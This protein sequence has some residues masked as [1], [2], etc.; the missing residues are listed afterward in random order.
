MDGHT[1]DLALDGPA[2]T[3]RLVDLP[4]VSGQ[5]K[6]LADA[7]EGALRPLAHLKVDR[8]GNNVVART[9][10][11]RAERVVLAGH[12]DTV[13]IADNVPSRLDDDGVL[14]GC[15]TSDMKAG[16][17][18]QLRIAA[19]VPEPNRDLTFV[20]YDNEEVAA[21]LN[22]LGKVAEAHPEWLE[23]DFA[24]LL[25][26]SDGEV[27]GGCQGTLRMHLRLDGERSHSA[28]SWMGSNAVH[29][30]APVL[31]KLASYEPRRP[32]IDGLEYREGLNAVGIEG[33][34]AT[35][36]IPDA[37]T[38]VVNYRYAPD[39]TPEQAEAHVHEVFADC[40]VAA[41]TVDDHSGAAM[42]GL[43]HP[44]AVA[45]MAAVGGTARPKFG[46]TDVSRFGSLGVPAVNYGPGDPLFAHKRDEHVRTELITHCEE[47]L[48]SWL[49]S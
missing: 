4:S 21:H 11:G 22:G 26:P 48:R 45:F 42:P 40:G 18:V 38:V 49:T 3:A 47:R 25:E 35:N 41:F 44:A 28:R 16:V 2:L 5:E 12:I 29:A 24:V 23:G 15:G 32:V 33:G 27:E 6:D 7:I 14:W 39:L 9:Q 43:S 10:L 1:L 34:V 19:T 31:A 17:A 30:A 20:F 46:W 37:C 13:P 36:V 8:Y